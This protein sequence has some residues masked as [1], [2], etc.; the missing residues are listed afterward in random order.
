MSPLEAFAWYGMVLALLVA[1]IA[2][3]GAWILRDLD[4]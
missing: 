2:G 1:V 4:S 3:L